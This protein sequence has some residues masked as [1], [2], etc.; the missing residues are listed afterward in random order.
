MECEAREQRLL[1][2]S[3]A[4]TPGE[5]DPIRQEVADAMDGLRSGYRPA[6]DVTADPRWIQGPVQPSRT[7]CG[8]GPSP[9]RRNDP[10]TIRPRA[11][12]ASRLAR[13]TGG[14]AGRFPGGRANRPRG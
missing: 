1:L 2:A 8:A 10:G 4:V 7:G 3:A 6:I 9:W 14:I 5:M 13:P 11:G 12:T